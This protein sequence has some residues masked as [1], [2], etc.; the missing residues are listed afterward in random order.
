MLLM[1]W[2]RWDKCYWVGDGL[3]AEWIGV[4]CYGGDGWVFYLREALGGWWKRREIK[5]EEGLGGD[6]DGFFSFFLFLCVSSL[7]S[8]VSRWSTE[9]RLFLST[10]VPGYTLG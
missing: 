7:S 3:T 6:F 4:G 1:S 5:P 2:T 10:F 9:S 8:T